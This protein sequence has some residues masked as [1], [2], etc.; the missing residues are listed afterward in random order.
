MDIPTKQFEGDKQAGAML[1]HYHRFVV[2][3]RV[4]VCHFGWMFGNAIPTLKRFQVMSRLYPTRQSRLLSW[5]GALM[6]CT[7]ALVS[8][9]AS[10]TAG[11]PAGSDK[12]PTMAVEDLYALDL[13]RV[14]E[15]VLVTGLY[16]REGSRV[17]IL[18]AL[19]D[20][21]EASPT[22]KL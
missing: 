1:C 22:S 19:P 18:E 11:E 6:A 4:Q 5:L 12:A 16:N 14:P 7:A 2:I 8:G 17:F 15:E 13:A 20:N 10:A 3:D 21:W 9:P